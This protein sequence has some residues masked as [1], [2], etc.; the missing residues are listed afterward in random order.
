MEAPLSRGDPDRPPPKRA[1]DTRGAGPLRAT[2]NGSGTLRAQAA[3][4]RRSQA[5][6]HRAGGWGEGGPA[7]LIYAQ[8]APKGFIYTAGWRWRRPPTAR[9]RPCTRPPPASFGSSLTRLVTRGRAT[10]AQIGPGS[11][12]RLGVTPGF[13]MAECVRAPLPATPP[14]LHSPTSHTIH[15][16]HR[17][18]TDRGRRHSPPLREV[19]GQVLRAG[20]PGQVADVELGGHLA[21]LGGGEARGF[22]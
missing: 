3:A 19:V 9:W 11:G 6:S 22:S 15:A 20:G 13:S 5:P 10:G 17:S 18:G 14:T 7:P 21:G 4:R 12:W 1:P 2:S 16:P 8:V